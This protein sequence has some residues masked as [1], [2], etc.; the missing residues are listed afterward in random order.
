MLWEPVAIETVDATL[1]EQELV[2]VKPSLPELSGKMHVKNTFIELAR[3][4]CRRSLKR[5]QSDSAL[6]ITSTVNLTWQQA[7]DSSSSFPNISQVDAKPDA[8]TLTSCLP[9]GSGGCIDYSEASTD[10]PRESIEDTSWC[11]AVDSSLVA[12]SW[13]ESS[14]TYAS[15]CM[16]MGCSTYHQDSSCYYSAIDPAS[17]SMNQQTN[18]EGL[19][20]NESGYMS[21]QG[22]SVSEMQ[23]YEPMDESWTVAGS[24][25]N[26]AC[27]H[28][29]GFIQ[30][31]F[32][33]FGFKAT[34]QEVAND[35]CASSLVT[36][37][38]SHHPWASAWE[39]STQQYREATFL[40][41]H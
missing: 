8:L 7:P 23:V 3:T 24:A 21:T 36:T 32:P 22:Q 18:A 2:V 35:S 33:D 15:Q 11:D 12:D 16:F 25:P 37:S 6:V 17:M 19:F 9:D 38:A 4:P 20:D 1:R 30:D 39:W 10:T 5:S 28:Q 41:H 14:D 27:H 31:T 29:D 26:G 40:N 13:D 34:Q